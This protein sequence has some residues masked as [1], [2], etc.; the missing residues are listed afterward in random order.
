MPNRV[1][2]IERRA[3][4]GL[5][6]IEGDDFRLQLDG[7]VHHRQHHLTIEL[8]DRIHVRLHQLKKRL[9]PDQAH[10]HSLRESL[11]DLALAERIEEEYQLTLEEIVSSGESILKQHLEEIAEAE[12]EQAAEEEAEVAQVEETDPEA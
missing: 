8:A 1:P 3:Q 9:P 12:R 7:L 11:I 4:P 6:L 5:L 2:K 10:L